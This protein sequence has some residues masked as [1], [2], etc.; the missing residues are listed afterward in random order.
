LAVTVR[1]ADPSG[2]EYVALTPAPTNRSAHYA[3]ITLR[4]ALNTMVRRWEETL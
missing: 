3:A 1:A 4:G 2:V